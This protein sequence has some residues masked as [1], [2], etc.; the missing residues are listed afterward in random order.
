[1]P[2]SVAPVRRAILCAAHS[3]RCCREPIG[4][5]LNHP[6]MR[7]SVPSVEPALD[8]PDDAETVE[9]RRPLL[10]RFAY[11]AGLVT[12][13]QTF[14]RRSHHGGGVGSDRISSDSALKL[15][16]GI[17]PRLGGRAPEIAQRAKPGGRRR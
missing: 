6:I 13:R 9:G 17:E 1:M 2:P 5:A 4:A 14:V 10:S 11:R 3:I 12:L 15:A 16:S 7:S 8:L